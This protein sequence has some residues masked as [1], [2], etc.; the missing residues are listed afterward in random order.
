MGSATIQPTFFPLEMAQVE[1]SLH[2]AHD[3]VELADFRAVHGSTRLTLGRGDLRLKPHTGIW[4]D[5]FVDTTQRTRE[6]LDGVA[7][8]HPT[9]ADDRKLAGYYA[10]YMDEAAIEQKGIAPVAGFTRLIL[11]RSPCRSRPSR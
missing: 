2:Y 7:A 4:A 3:R 11:L 10:T 8:A 1:G 6:L 9:G 5:L